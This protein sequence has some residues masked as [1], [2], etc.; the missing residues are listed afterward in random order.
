VAKYWQRVWERDYIAIIYDQ[1]ADPF[2]GALETLGFETITE[3]I[4]EGKD[5]SKENSF[6][7]VYEKGYRTIHL[8][9]DQEAFLDDAARITVDNG[10]LGEDYFWILSGIAL[11]PALLPT[12]RYQVDSLVDKM[13][14]GAA[15]FTNRLPGH[16]LC[17][18]QQAMEAQ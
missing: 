12:L 6:E 4:A 15:V 13:L 9:T 2:E 3:P 14:R 10:L 5:E 16:V 7:E 17:P 8:V 11:L 1:S 18:F